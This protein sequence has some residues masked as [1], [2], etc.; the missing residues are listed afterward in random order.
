LEFGDESERS[1]GEI[2]YIWKMIGRPDL[3]L[4]WFEKVRLTHQQP[5]EC[6]AL[7]GDCWADLLED[8]RAKGAYESATAFQ[9]DHADGWMGLCRLKL[10]IGD[11]AAAREIYLREIPRYPQSQ[12]ARR[13]AAL[14]EF[15]ARNIPEAEK[16]YR[17]LAQEDPLGGI[18]GG[19]YNAVDYRSALA[20][21]QLLRGHSEQARP[22]L[23]S[24]LADEEKRV[25]R[26]PA[27]PSAHYRKAALKSMLGED[28]EALSALRLA[29]DCGWIDYRATRI[30]PRFDR[31]N[32]TP[33]FNAILLDASRKVETIAQRRADMP[34]AVNPK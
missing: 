3:A 22:T 27:D 8:G 12:N 4:R 24:C 7:V 13:M 6:D 21:L 5:A 1:F 11:Y 33:E 14:V 29:V 34:L 2:G 17:E 26:F 10:L 16:R 32:Q 28:I 30:D 18:K 15:F 19:F 25:R 23:L 31:I 20:C 9:P